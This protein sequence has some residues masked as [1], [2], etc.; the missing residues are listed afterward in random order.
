[1]KPKKYISKFYALIHKM[2]MDGKID[3]PDKYTAVK[4]IEI[5]VHKLRQA[6]EYAGEI[7]TD[8]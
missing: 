5:A 2:N 3:A 8:K 7:K 1:M 4:D 6:F